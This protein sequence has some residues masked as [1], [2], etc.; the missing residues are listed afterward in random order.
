MLNGSDGWSFGGGRTSHGDETAPESHRCSLERLPRPSEAKYAAYEHK[1]SVPTRRA[2][3][4]SV[5]PVTG[6][7]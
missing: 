7:T 6:N 1:G 3:S 4:A 2:E 5:V